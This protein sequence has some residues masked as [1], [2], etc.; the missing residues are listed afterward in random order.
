MPQDARPIVAGDA[1]IVVAPLCARALLELAEEQ[2]Q[3]DAVA[4][5]LRTLRNLSRE[6]AEFRTLAANPRIARSALAKAVRQVAEAAKFNVL[7]ANFLALAAQNRRLPQLD[8]MIAAFLAALAAARGEFAAEVQ[9]AEVLT[10]GQ[11]ERLSAQL[12]E[13]LTGGKVHVH[14]NQDKSL[15]GGLVVELGSRLIDA[16]VKGRLER[17]ERQL[18]SPGSRRLQGSSV[19]TW[20]FAS[21][22]NFIDSEKADRRFRRGDR[23]GGS[24]PG[25]VGRRRRGARVWSR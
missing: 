25:A 18:K 4:A 1:A 14:I 19:E 20:T 11:Q 5:D 23:S 8:A 7:T 15:I 13:A 22:R 2:K 10:P 24:R 3:L 12:P 16:S 17:L 9:A 21:C 6:S